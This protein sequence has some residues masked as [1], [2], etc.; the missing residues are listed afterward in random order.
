MLRDATELEY[1][2]PGSSEAMRLRC[3]LL[4]AHQ[5]WNAGLAALTVQNLPSSLRPQAS[6]IGAGIAGVCWSGRLQI[7]E[8]RG[9]TWLLDVAHNAAAVE[10]LAQALTGLNLPE[11]LALVVAIMGDKPW[12]EMLPP[13]LALADASVFTTAPSSPPERRWNA[14]AVAATISSYS[15]EVVEDFPGA[16]ERAMEIGQTIVVTGSHHT[17]GDAMRYLDIPVGPLHDKRVGKTDG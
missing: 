8:C 6:E 14:R 11:P 16:L 5:A 17:V 15:V 1:V 9:R 12:P 10:V 13:L 2:G 7:E 4:G 3:P